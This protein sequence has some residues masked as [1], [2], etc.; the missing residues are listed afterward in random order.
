ML[1]AVIILLF[2]LNSFAFL[3]FIGDQTKK[4]M[5][6]GVYIDSASELVSEMIPDEDLETGAKDIQKRTNK[7]RSESGNINY[8]TRSTQTLLKGP[9]W[10]SKRIDTNMRSTTDYIR[11]LK[12]LI[13]RAA[14]LGND[15]VVAL[16]TTETNI[17]LNEVQKNQ[18]ALIMQNSDS[19]LRLIEREHEEAQQWSN[20]SEQ[21]RK[22]RNS[23]VADGKL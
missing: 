9:E 3:D 1:I 15:G 8:L 20:F 4:A 22:L 13:A 10:S 5:E 14:A 11:K 6:V 17:A 16:N 12:R 19:Q 21:Q 18:Q 23:K 2:S 7:L